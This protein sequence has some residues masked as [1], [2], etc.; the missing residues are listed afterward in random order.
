MPLPGASG[1]CHVAPK[2][3]IVMTGVMTTGGGGTYL[4]AMQSYV[5]RDPP[6]CSA[7]DWQ[8]INATAYIF[9][10]SIPV[11][12][13]ATLVD[14]G[15]E[16]GLHL[17]TDCKNWMPSGGGERVRGGLDAIYQQQLAAF[18]GELYQFATA[19]ACHGTHALHRME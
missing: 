16:I 4:A 6:H 19:T 14:E 7:D 10:G 17:S 11:K 8:C 18:G 2:R 12:R 3:A 1:T 5:A 9:D 13:A 15:F